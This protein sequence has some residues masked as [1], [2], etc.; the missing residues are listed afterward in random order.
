MNFIAT[1]FK[2]HCHRRGNV[3][4]YNLNKQQYLLKNM[5]VLH[6][7]IIPNLVMYY[8]L[9]SFNINFLNF[10]EFVIIVIFIFTELITH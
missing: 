4:I 10:W 5:L 3:A 9:R 1:R 6:G 2:N 8:V 7:N